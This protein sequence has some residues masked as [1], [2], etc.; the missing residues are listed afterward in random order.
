MLYVPAAEPGCV[1]FTRGVGAVGW[2]VR[3]GSG[4]HYAHSEVVHHVEVLD[5]GSLRL[6]VVASY[7]KPF[8]D[9]DG[10]RFRTRTI[11]PM[12][13][14]ELHG[15]CVVRPWRTEDERQAVLIMSA[16]V[17]EAEVSYGYD[18][19]CRICLRGIGIRTAPTEDMSRLICSEHCAV[20]VLNGRPDLRPF[21]PVPAQS[22]WPGLLHA[23]LAE[24]CDV[25]EPVTTAGSI[26]RSL[27]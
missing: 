15:Y 26:G 13:A 21:F 5:D 20:S 6:R 18:S 2:T 16:A 14:S 7:A 24:H 10:P 17:A 1:L 8:R 4:A 11:K 19:L 27:A 25:L 12:P 23:I 22:T 3:H 9:D